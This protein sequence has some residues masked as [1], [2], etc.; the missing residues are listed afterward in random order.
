MSSSA[1]HGPGEVADPPEARPAVNAIR[2][3]GEPRV[4]ADGRVVEGEDD[5]PPRRQ[6][7]RPWGT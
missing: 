5:A 4:E 2:P 7:P 3:S 1:E 6:A